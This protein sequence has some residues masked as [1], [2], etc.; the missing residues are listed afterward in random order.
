MGSSKSNTPDSHERV[1]AQ[2]E[3]ELSQEMSQDEVFSAAHL[4]TLLARFK[5]LVELQDPSDR[6]ALNYEW[7]WRHRGG[8]LNFHL[9]VSVMIHGDEVG[10]LE[11]LIDFMEALAEGRIE[12]PGVF[13][14][15]IGN[16]EAARLQRRFVDLDLNRVI[17]PITP[18]HERPLAHE[19]LRAQR[20]LP[21]LDQFD[22]YIDF[23]QTILDSIHPFYICPWNV[24]TWR[25]MRIMGGAKMWV[26]RHPERGGGGL[27]CADEYVRQRGVPSVALELGVLGFSAQAR[28][29]VWRSLVRVINALVELD[30]GEITL[31]QLA[32]QQPELIFYETH[33]RY[34]FD[35]PAL[36]LAPGWV[37]FSPVEEGMTLTAEFGEDA[38][39][40]EETSEAPDTSEISEAPETSETSEISERASV[41]ELETSEIHSTGGIH[42]TAAS[43]ISSSEPELSS[44]STRRSSLTLHA[45]T[46]GALLFPKYPPRDEEGRALDPRPKELCRIVKLL[47]DHPL[48]LW[49]NSGEES[50]VAESQSAEES[51]EESTQDD[52][53]G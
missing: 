40:N 9:G 30:Q 53:Q 5:E 39:V 49:A 42:M 41:P 28:S 22:L 2:D 46:E 6:S 43:T 52:L 10:P 48:V 47:D 12:F 36:Q 37:N 31:E 15:L 20:L 19:V 38:N 24:D 8:E 13:T 18:D 44:L 4:E 11:G 26:T 25:W 23:H 50:G 33:T 7:S 21:L 45:T 27:K 32:E 29:R 3:Q 1:D 35:D 16:P 17:E 34:P 14:C 51:T